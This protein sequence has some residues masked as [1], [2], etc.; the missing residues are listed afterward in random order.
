MTRFGNKMKMI[1][2]EAV[3]TQRTVFFQYL[4]GGSRVGNTRALS[5]Y[6]VLRS[7]TQTKL[8]PHS[9][10]Q[11]CGVLTRRGGYVTVCLLFTQYRLT[12]YLSSGWS[13]PSSIL[14]KSELSMHACIHTYIHT[15]IHKYI[16]TCIHT[17][18]HTYIHTYIHTC[19]Y[20]YILYVFLLSMLHH[21]EVTLHII[22]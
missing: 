2:K 4:P 9:R 3:V 21:P 17:Y 20:T 7:D 8:L 12:H 13:G 19:I 16:H 6:S 22:M 15:Y 5:G 18:M 10:H 14:L 11:R 1:W